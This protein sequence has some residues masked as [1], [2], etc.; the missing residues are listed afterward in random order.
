MPERPATFEEIIT[1]L[2]KKEGVSPALALAVAQ[3]ESG[4]DP[5]AK[6]PK[7]A[8]GIMQLMPETA[9]DLGVDPLDPVQNISGGIKYLKTLSDRYQGDVQKT[10]MAYNGGMRWVDEGTPSPEAQAYASNVLARVSKGMRAQAG[11]PQPA[12]VKPMPAHAAQ[13]PPKQGILRAIVEPFNPLTREGRRNVAGA[14]GGIGGGILAAPT[15]AAS[16]PVGPATGAVLGAMATSGAVDLAEDWLDDHNVNLADVGKH[17]ATQGVYEMGGVIT[18][19]PV[20]R[21]ARAALATRVGQEAAEYIGKA[22]RAAGEAASDLLRTTRMRG[23]DAMAAARQAATD[24]LESTRQMSGN[25]VGSVQAK[26]EATVAR[27]AERSAASIAK[28][29]QDAAARL[30]QTELAAD[31]TVRDAAGTY[32]RMLAKPPSVTGAGTAVREVLGGLPGL[33]TVETGPAKRALDLAGQRIDAAAKS[34]PPV[35]MASIKESLNAM[36]EK[37]RPVSLF[38]GE[39]AP[40]GIGF[41]APSAGNIRAAAASVGGATEA[42]TNKLRAVIAQQLGITDAAHPLPGVLA[43]IQ[44]A[45]ESLSFADAHQLKRLLDEAVNYD[46]ASKK[47]LEGLTKGIRS[48]LRQAMAGHQP[49]DEATAAYQALV[50]LYRKGVG[51][52]IV[53]AAATNPDRVATMLKPDSPAAAQAL[54]DLLV[55]QAEAGGDAAMGQRAWDG[56]RSTFV[57]NNVLKGGVEGLGDRIAKLQQQSPEFVNVV[58]GDLQAQQIL[59]NLQRISAAYQTAVQQTT[60]RL[61]AEKAGAKTA[62]EGAKATGEAL[63]AGTKKVAEAEATVAKAQTARAERNAVREGRRVIE[64]QRK[65]NATEMTNAFQQARALRVGPRDLAERFKRSSI[66]QFV[67]ENAMESELANTARAAALGPTSVWGAL[68]MIRLMTKNA[69]ER[70]LLEWAAY[71]NEN[72][73]RVVG[74]LL[75]RAPDRIIA[76]TLRDAVGIVTPPVPS[77]APSTRPSQPPSPSGQGRIS[78]AGLDT[79]P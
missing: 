13:T 54:K 69:K 48:V 34:G 66:R 75:S 5:V 70:E 62:V 76:S 18:M 55:T 73:R 50:P 25:L 60:E 65:A 16:G 47:H 74:V 32:E 42:E 64:A 19:W 8:L 7:G 38:P 46:R 26:G 9:K 40:R 2:A 51:K 10:L 24:V 3:Q 27:T 22:G 41:F 45:P 15:A 68:S 17:M 52:Q 71:S 6:S 44:Q 29:Q 35:Q 11:Q 72:T 1:G 77:H 23:Q 43:K 67:N 4:L 33:Q 53:Q 30:A 39:E 56:V 12:S 21:V 63:V 79:Q 57:Y 78:V 14:L 49:Y 59:Q 28:V 20:R 36:A 61:A 31:A 37:V 58:F